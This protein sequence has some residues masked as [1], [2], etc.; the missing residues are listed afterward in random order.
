MSGSENPNPL[1]MGDE[2][3]LNMTGPP[4]AAEENAGDPE[5]E[6]AKEA[7]TPTEGV[8]PTEPAEEGEPAPDDSE[9]AAAEED[10]EDSTPAADEENAGEKEENTETPKPKDSSE[11]AIGE[12]EGA[13]EAGDG[14]SS[15]KQPSESE[16][17]ENSPKPTEA[18]AVNYEAAYKEIM[19]P[20]KANN[21]TITLKDPKEAISLM[22]MGANYTRKLQ[23]IQPHRKVL[24]MLQDN[25]L[26][27]EGKLSYLIDLDKKDP[28][29]IKKLIKDSG[30]DVMD[31]DTDTEP[32]Y[33]PGNHQVSDKEAAFRGVLE[34]VNS[35]EL[36]S[37]TLR[38]I[39]ETWDDASKEM[40]WESP[41]VMTVIQTQ[42][43]NGVYD[44]IYDEMNR[45]TTLGLIPA[46][47]PFMQS[48]RDVGADLVKQN[49]FSDL[50]V[51]ASAKPDVK[52][53]RKK[54]AE[55]AAVPKSKVANG[56]KASAASTSRSTSKKSQAIVNPLD[57]SD[58]EFLGKMADRL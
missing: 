40:I 4:A 44:L 42:R 56:E 5:K 58:E 18:E 41:E 11:A 10:G 54:L 12:A 57:M 15:E 3:I 9:P 55:K 52:P 51:N 31:I 48:Y 34:E 27:D 45:R 20:F 39:E 53:E 38:I 13:A 24:L 36:G 43:E 23:D 35:S 21:K 14:K 17:P 29:A 26:L 37:E 33:Q 8:E 25:K 22:Q 6:E 47:T 19:A 30:I 46:N 2:D 16:S 50:E 7:E 28:E 32:N 1:E 49:A